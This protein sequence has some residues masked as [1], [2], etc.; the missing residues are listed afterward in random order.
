MTYIK[1]N[2]HCLSVQVIQGCYGSYAYIYLSE[3]SV[4]NVRKQF[5]TERLLCLMII[6]A[7]A[8]H[9]SVNLILQVSLTPYNASYDDYTTPIL[10]RYVYDL[11]SGHQFA[12]RL[13]L[14]WPHVMTS[15]MM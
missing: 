15:L 6:A 5:N 4:Y 8:P 12:P 13:N 2:N 11:P 10:G 9:G 14:P 3:T 7:A 1:F